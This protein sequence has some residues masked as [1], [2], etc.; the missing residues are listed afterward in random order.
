LDNCLTGI[1]SSRC[2]FITD[3]LKASVYL[4]I[5]N[6]PPKLNFMSNFWGALHIQSAAFLFENFNFYIL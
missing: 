2:F 3:I 5:K 6:A 1:S 4:D